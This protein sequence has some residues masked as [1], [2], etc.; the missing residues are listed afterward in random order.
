MTEVAPCRVLRSSLDAARVR[1]RPG[2]RELRT[3]VHG[4]LNARHDQLYG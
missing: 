4:M 1:R 3:L 2:D